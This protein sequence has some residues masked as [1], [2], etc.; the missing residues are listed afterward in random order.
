MMEET[1]WGEFKY[2]LSKKWNSFTYLFRR[3]YYRLRLF[4]R[5]CKTPYYGSWELCNPILD[6]P[7]EILCE[8]WEIHGKDIYEGENNEHWVKAKREMERLYNWYKYDRL[9]RQRELD[10]LLHIWSEQSKHWTTRCEDKEGFSQWHNAT[11]KYGEHLFKMLHEEEAKYEQEKED[12]LIALIKIRNY[13][14][15]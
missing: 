12:A 6:Y 11:S 15:D 1:R 3:P 9:E 8:Y 10:Y 13:L 5:F 4:K 2:E 7:F 14:W